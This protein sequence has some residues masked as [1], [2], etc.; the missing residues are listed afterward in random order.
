MLILLLWYITLIVVCKLTVM[1]V[2]SPFMIYYFDVLYKHL[3]DNLVISLWQNG[4]FFVHHIHFCM[5]T[6][7][8]QNRST[9]WRMHRLKH[10]LSVTS[11]V[12]RIL[13][14][15][16][17]GAWCVYSQYSTLSLS[18]LSLS[19]SLS[20]SVSLSLSLCISLSLPLSLCI[21]H[22]LSHSASVILMY[23]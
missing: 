4:L 17:I 19:L 11:L 22:T 9:I 20:I 1:H 6:C 7:Q 23:K 18:S 10:S 8:I 3:S 14:L 12:G 13:S 5:H 2:N 21:S 15:V 16:V